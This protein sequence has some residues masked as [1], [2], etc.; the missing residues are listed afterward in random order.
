MTLA[1][2]EPKKIYIRVDEWW[3]PWTNTIAYYP[4]DWDVNDHSWNN[5]NMTVATGSMSYGNLTDGQ[6]WI[7]NGSTI[8]TTYNMVSLNSGTLTMRSLYSNNRDG[9]VFCNNYDVNNNSYYSNFMAI[10][11]GTTMYVPY[12]EWS[13]G[14]TARLAA[15]GTYSA[16]QWYFQTLTSDGSTLSYYLNGQYVTSKSTSFFMN[17]GNINQW[18]IWGLKRW[19]QTY[20]ILNWWVSNLIIEN[21]CRT[22]QEISDY[23]NLTKS[24]YGIS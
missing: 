1:Q 4:L 3:Q 22:A 18:C 14:T 23:Y 17:M 12:S 24:L 15:T 19:S 8:L 6:Y 20:S 10:D 5:R 7:F 9:L 11:S 2:T 13:F 21:K 16:N